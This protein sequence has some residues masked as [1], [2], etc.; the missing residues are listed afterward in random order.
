MKIGISVTAGMVMALL[1]GCATQPEQVPGAGGIVIDTWG[2][3]MNQYQADLAECK[4]IAYSTYSDQGRRGA[5]GAAGGAVVGGALG[6]IVGD[7]SRAAVAGAGAGA[8]VGGL[9]GTG[10]AGAEATYIIKN[11]LRG[12]GYRVLN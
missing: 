6:A 1:Y 3:N 5:V 8:L 9:S 11:C 4:G 10:S 7:S 2:V 12:R